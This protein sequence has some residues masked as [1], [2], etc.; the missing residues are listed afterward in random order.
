MTVDP[1]SVMFWT[2]AMVAGWKAI[3]EES[4]TMDWFWVGLWM[5]LGFLS[6]YT[7][8]FQLLSWLRHFHS[9]GRLRASNGTGPA[10]GWR[11]W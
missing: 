10:H 2:L 7:A 9:A 1:L 11:C 5:G 4:S 8:L 3:Q 6:K